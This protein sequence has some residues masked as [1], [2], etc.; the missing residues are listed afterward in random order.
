MHD[1]KRASS[2][3][4]SIKRN[5]FLEKIMNMTKSTKTLFSTVA[6]CLVIAFA[7]VASVNASDNDIALDT[8][9]DYQGHKSKGSKHNMKRMDKAL[10]LSEQ[11]QVQI[12]AIKTQAR[13]QRQ[14]LRASMKEFKIAERKIMQTKSFDEKAFN[15]L[16][17]LYQPTFTQLALIKVK[18]KHAVFNV[19]TTEQQEKWLKIIE[20]K[21]NKRKAKSRDA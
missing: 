8:S 18:S 19:L 5:Y 12:K 15:A 17:D 20:R 13:E 1:L 6:I 10:S 14:A 9:R 4:T 21:K 11:Q 2:S 16:H 3:G 7:S